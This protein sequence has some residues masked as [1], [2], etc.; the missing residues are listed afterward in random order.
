VKNDQ[1]FNLIKS[2]TKGEKRFFKLYASRL[3][4]SEDKKFIILFEAIDQQTNYSESKILKKESSLNPKQFSNLKAHLYYQILKAVRLMNSSKQEDLNLITLLDY[5]RILYNKC[6][7]REC[8]KMID[9]AKVI[10]IENDRSLILLEILE[11]E[12]QVI[13]KTIESGNQKRVNELVDTTNVVAESIR[14]INV[15]SNLSLKLNSFYIHTGFSKSEEDLIKLKSFFYESLPEYNEE[16]LSFQEKQYLYQ[17]YI[18]YYFYIQNLE[19]G[20]YYAKRLVLLFE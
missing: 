5:A 11:L 17:S 8:V 3:K 16:N 7:Y 9:K 13:P 14:N 18:G 1:L 19:S 15:F 6:L 2:L 12:K 20:Y 4:N 10:A